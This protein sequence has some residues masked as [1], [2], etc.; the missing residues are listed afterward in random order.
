MVYP[1]SKLTLIPLLLS[2]I[3]GVEGLE[4][5]PK[6]P[7]YILAINHLSY[8]DSMIISALIA[9][10]RNKKVSFLTQDNDQFY[11]LFGKKIANEWASCI[12][13]SN[14]EYALTESSKRLKQNKI[15]GIHPEGHRSRNPMKMLRGRT[16]MTRLA[17]WNHVNIIPIGIK[18]TEKIM[19]PP[20]AKIKSLKR[21]I[22]IKI[23]KPISLKEYYK[24]KITKVLLRSLT[25][26]IMK[27]IAKLSNQ[28]YKT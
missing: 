26:K 3:K 23:G 28:E 24:H 19:P 8:I 9:K 11:R 12:P 7:P 16:G 13:I 15:I 20:G 14:K 18:G 4:N 21:I 17:L 27:E 25:N 2:R 1:I 22:T 5:L 10:Y 6:N